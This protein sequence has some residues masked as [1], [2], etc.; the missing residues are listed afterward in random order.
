M[1]QHPP[2]VARRQA[3]P[4]TISFR[5]ADGRITAGGWSDLAPTLVLENIGCERVVYVTRE[6][7]ESSFATKIAKHLG[8]SEADWKKLYDLGDAASSYNLSIEK[9]DAVWCTNWNAFSDLQQ[10][11]KALDA[12]GAPLETRAS[13]E[14]VRT[15]SPYANVTDRTGKPGCTPGISGGAPY[16]R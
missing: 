6:G 11:E 1:P 12:W 15:L 3:R 8:M 14:G 13:F 16:P 4:S 10:R 5:V 7:D 9:A 2:F